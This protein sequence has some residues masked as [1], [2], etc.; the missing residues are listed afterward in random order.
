MA[1]LSLEQ[2]VRHVDEI[3][4]LPD[5]AMAVVRLAE[6]PNSSL[7]EIVTIIGTDIA[8]TSRV[9]RIANSAY[10]GLARQ[11]STAGEAVMIL[12]MQSVRD[13]AIAAAA[14]GTLQ[15]DTSGYGMARGVL[16]RHSVAV[17]VSAQLIARRVPGIRPPEAFAAGLL[18]DM[19]KVVLH[20]HVAAQMM[21]ILALIQL[22]G[23]PFAAAEKFVLGFDHA[24][25]GGHIAEKW[26]LPCSLCE[27]I[28]GHHRRD[29]VAK[30]RSL[31]TVVHV[32]NAA[33]AAEGLYAALPNRGDRLELAALEVLGLSE[34]DM[35]TI[36]DETVAHL[37]NCDDL[38]RQSAA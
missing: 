37:A 26:N 7:R 24:E 32:A 15:M 10:Y 8:L 38:Y 29:V 5:A 21:A 1:T 27:A 35:Q 17:A 23:M 2:L 6:D 12:G 30:E 18:H 14:A 28:A 31:A 13:L 22:D 9:L 36:Q 20:E 3:P 4:A 11:V 33:S 25:T 34:T 19:G 16:W